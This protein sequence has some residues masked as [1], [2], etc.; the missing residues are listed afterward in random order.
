MFAETPEEVVRFWR[1]IEYCNFP[2]FSLAKL[3]L[4]YLPPSSSL[5]QRF[6]VFY[7]ENNDF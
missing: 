2:F 5:C 6:S 7:L 4:K 1:K 3:Q